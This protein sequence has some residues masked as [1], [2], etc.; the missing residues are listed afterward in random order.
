MATFSQFS[1]DIGV[2]AIARAISAFADQEYTDAVRIAGTALIGADSRISTNEEDYFGTIRWQQTLGALAYDATAGSNSRSATNINIGTEDATEGALTDTSYD[3]SVYIKTVRSHGARNYN[4]TQVL[5]QRE[6]AIEKIS[7]DFGVT[8]ARDADEAL[9]AMARGV[10]QAEV[11]R[12][13]DGAAAVSV[14]NRFGQ[15]YT[16]STYLNANAGFYYDV[17]GPQNS[18]ATDN[19]A[20]RTARLIDPAAQGG[21][22][23]SALWRAAGAFGDLE[24]DFFYL[25]I[26]PETYQD[27]RA[28]NLLDNQDRISDGNV[29][30]DTLL[31]GKFRL[32]VTRS[33]GRGGFNMAGTAGTGTGQDRAVNAGSDRTSI[34]MLPGVLYQHDVSVTNPVAFDNDESVGRGTGDREL[35]YRWGNVWHPRGYTWTGLTNAFAT[36]PNLNATIGAAAGSNYADGVNWQRKE[37]PGNLGI[38]P[39]FHA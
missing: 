10:M 6:G 27:V 22:A 9:L 8:R 5:T 15:G 26:S 32:V 4:T 2:N 18:A 23:A 13:I 12:R 21:G 20:T 24:P 16:D 35:W 19:A 33:L 17:N 7:R 14:G 31:Q 38:L 3:S 30:L 29:Q 37:T 39:I 28:A 34:L 11:N 1:G 36:N 25:V